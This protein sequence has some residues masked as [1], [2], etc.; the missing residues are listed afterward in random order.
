MH[1]LVLY[2]SANLYKNITSL[3]WKRSKDKYIFCSITSK[4][5]GEILN[6]ND[7]PEFRIPQN[8]VPSTEVLQKTE[9]RNLI[10][11]AQNK[12]FRKIPA[13]TLHTSIVIVGNQNNTVYLE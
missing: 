12:Y 9:F 5:Y 13:Y 11:A 3:K 2:S 10:P 8:T 7:V 6:R 4:K 1:I